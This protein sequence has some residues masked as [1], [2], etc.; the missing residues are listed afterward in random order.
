MQ[1][2]L[3]ASL[4]IQR[5]SQLRPAMSKRKEVEEKVN[6]LNSHLASH[7]K[8][9]QELAVVINDK[10]P[11]EK[12]ITIVEINEDDSVKENMS[13]LVMF[14][15]KIKDFVQDIDECL[16]GVLSP[17]DYAKVANIT[18]TTEQ[19]LDVIKTVTKGLV[20]LVGPMVS[21]IARK[22]LSTDSLNK[23]EHKVGK[24]NDTKV[25]Q[26][27]HEAHGTNDVSHPDIQNNIQDL[28]DAIETLKP[29]EKDDF[30]STVSQIIMFTKWHDKTFND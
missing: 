6:K 19:V 29:N 9:A 12:K 11:A 10:V 27:L 26:A 3:Q 30:A 1:L 20:S 23:L 25:M 17:E 13:N 4:T 16:E 21:T 2:R 7:Y 24:A 18:A 28:D 5:L 14:I 22:L 15:Q 8:A